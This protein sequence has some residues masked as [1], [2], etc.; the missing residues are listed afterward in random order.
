MFYFFKKSNKMNK[1]NNI[2]INN[3]NKNKKKKKKKK[4]KKNIYFI[5]TLGGALTVTCDTSTTSNCGQARAGANGI[6]WLARASTPSA[7][8]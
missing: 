3:N 6:V 4:K 2:I 8:R 5:P 1:K 7:V